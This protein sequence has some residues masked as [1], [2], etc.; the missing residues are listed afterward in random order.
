MNFK[1][2]KFLLSF[3]LLVVFLSESAF[4]L[5]NCSYLSKTSLEIIP[6]LAEIQN[7]VSTTECSSYQQVLKCFDNN[8]TPDW[9]G[10]DVFKEPFAFCDEVSGDIVT[11]GIDKK[12]LGDSVKDC[13]GSVPILIIPAISKDSKCKATQGLYE[14]CRPKDDP[15]FDTNCLGSEVLF[16]AAKSKT[17]KIMVTKIISYTE[18]KNALGE[19]I[20]MTPSISPS[21]RFCETL[22]HERFHAYQYD[23]FKSS[24]YVRLEDECKDDKRWKESKGSEIIIWKKILNDLKQSAG[25]SSKSVS[26]EL[27]KIK[28]IRNSYSKNCSDAIKAQERIEGTAFH[29][30]LDYLLKNKLATRSDY[31]K[32]ADVY[33]DKSLNSPNPEENIYPYSS[34]LILI[35]LASQKDMSWAVAIE[36]GKTPW[37]LVFNED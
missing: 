23:K 19:S 32:N 3:T 4:A 11:L 2:T 35:L 14:M 12:F 8:S 36:E 31:F 24:S 37:S 21:S 9:R 7:V 10:W 26:L 22:I 20:K 1:L 16:N 13:N 29:F 15:G 5:D 30:G 33:L 6:G 34:G 18:Q 25:K 27:E 17:S 28:K